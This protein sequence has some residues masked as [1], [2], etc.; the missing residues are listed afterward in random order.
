MAVGALNARVDHLLRQLRKMRCEF[1][2]LILGERREVDG[3]DRTTARACAPAGVDRIAFRARRHDE[4]DLA[5]GD[6]GGD[7]A[8]SRQLVG[9]RPVHVLDDQ[10]L[11]SALHG[12]FDQLREGQRAAALTGRDL[13]RLF[14][15][16][17]L[18]VDRR[19][20]EIAEEDDLIDGIAAA[21]AR[22]VT[23][24]QRVRSPGASA[25][26]PSRLSASAV[27]GRRP[28]DWPKSNT[29]A[30]C[31]AT[32]RS[33]AA[34]RTAFDQTASCR[35]RLRRAR[36]SRGRDGWWCSGRATRESSRAPAAGR[37]TAARPGQLR[38]AI[39]A[40]STRRRSQHGLAERSRRA[41]R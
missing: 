33:R 26:R 34:L 6:D 16:R 19:V 27:I 10:Q 37:R 30:E 35:Y 11:R 28:G 15:R 14:Q 20:D 31:T 32:P 17:E 3:R 2:R 22:A 39:P 12:R 8:E 4:Q 38:C 36:R 7:L 40:G 41:R 29:C 21:P 1:L 5:V 23:A 9:I 18:R 24:V 13:H 25:P